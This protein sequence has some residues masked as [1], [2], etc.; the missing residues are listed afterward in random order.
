MSNKAA[1][2]DN[3]SP[4]GHSYANEPTEVALEV[5]K[6]GTRRMV[7]A[8]V[9]TQ[10]A[11]R[12]VDETPAANVLAPPRPPKDGAPGVGEHLGR[13][14]L[15]DELGRGFSSVVYKAHHKMLDIDVALK[16]L[17]DRNLDEKSLE[18]VYRESHLLALLNHPGIIRILD[19]DKIDNW[20]IVILEFVDGLALRT[21]SEQ[22]GQM[23]AT[24]VIDVIL[25][26]AQALRYAHQKGVI[27]NDIKPANILLMKDGAVKVADLGMA[28]VVSQGHD[29]A[30]STQVCGTPGYISPEMVSQGL[31]AADHRSDI[32]SL[33]VSMFQCLAGRLPFLQED[34]YQLMVAHVQE[35]PPALIELLPKIDIGLATL[36]ACMMSKRPEDR[37]QNYDQLIDDLKVIQESL[38]A[39]ASDSHMELF[40][41]Q[42]QAPGDQPAGFLKRLFRR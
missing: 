34:P 1:Q 3:L 16:V 12:V 15:T 33:G 39:G 8:K 25:Q 23:E 27:H 40:F 17:L 9:A 29:L 32:Y 31:R 4:T 36:V 22:Q 13:F 42:S 6:E 24:L 30:A 19:F 11:K 7:R 14:L 41:D 5:L 38:E 26:A 10:A 20:H 21:L 2:D 37:P 18:C 28:K 35:E